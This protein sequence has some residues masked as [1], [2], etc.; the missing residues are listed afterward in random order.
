MARGGINK[1][2]VQHARA[3][4][5]GRGR[6]PS[7]D[8]VRIELGNTGS[9]STISRYL[10]ELD[11][12]ALPAVVQSQETAIDQQLL[13][14][15]QALRNQLLEQ[16]QAQVTQE[17]ARSV[18]REQ[19]L[20]EQLFAAQEELRVCHEQLEQLKIQL[21]EELQQRQQQ[22]IQLATQTEA[23]RDARQE[24]HGLNL[25]QQQHLVQ[26]EQ[27]QAAHEHT[28][29]NLEHFREQSREQNAAQKHQHEQFRQDS[30]QQQRKLELQLT[31]ALQ[32][33]E[34]LNGDL[35]AL[36]LTL[37]LERQRLRDQDQ[38]VVLLE[39]TLERLNHEHQLLLATRLS[40]S[41]LLAQA[42]AEVKALSAQR[43]QLSL[44]LVL[45][46]NRLAD[47]QPVSP[48]MADEPGS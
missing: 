3:A 32:R 20:L 19:Q 6:R 21:R 17:Q 42:S 35:G 41:E 39:Q 28:R 23:M 40:Q 46:H 36:N 43:D 4:L 38:R 10:K 11:A 2:L 30:H 44:D 5:L 15:V 18:E 48:S 27:L 9:K 29:A 1:A 14:G 25:T 33:V 31:H 12:A 16:A 37:A 13:I 45:C 22:A 7:I 24:L 26:I 34:Q 8:A 47:A